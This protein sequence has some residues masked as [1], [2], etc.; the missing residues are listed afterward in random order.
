[1]NR[2]PNTLFCFHY[3]FPVVFITIFRH[4]LHLF[5]LGFMMISLFLLLRSPGHFYSK[6][7]SKFQGFISTNRLSLLVTIFW[8][9]F[10]TNTLIFY[11]LLIFVIPNSRKHNSEHPVFSLMC[12]DPNEL[13]HRD[14]NENLGR[15]VRFPF[16]SSRFI[17]SSLQ[18]STLQVSSFNSSSF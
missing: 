3:D 7:R 17:C 1:M 4:L 11:F 13:C 10:I 9:T 5:A 14:R 2:I 18:V 16:K 8:T 6:L 12:G 15:N